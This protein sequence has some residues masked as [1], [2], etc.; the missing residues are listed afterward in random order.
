MSKR[1]KI[2]FSINNQKQEISVELPKPMSTRQ[3]YRFLTKLGF[4]NVCLHYYGPILEGGE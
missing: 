4:K 2:Q 3:I 1:V